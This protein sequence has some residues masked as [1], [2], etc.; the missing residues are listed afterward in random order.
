M[1]KR[2]QSP[3]QKK[4]ASKP[5]EELTERD[6]GQ[7][8]GGVEPLGPVTKTPSPGGPIPVPYPNKA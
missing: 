5:R 8:S 7:V 1:A 2:T 3:K 4:P 6:L